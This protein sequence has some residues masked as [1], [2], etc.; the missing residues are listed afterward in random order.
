LVKRFGIGNLLF[1]S[2]IAAVIAAVL[3]RFIALHTPLLFLVLPF[4]LLGITWGLSNAGLITAVNEVISAKK[5][6][7]AL[8]TVATIW[9]VT[10]A[11]ILALSTAIFHAVESHSSFLP[12]FHSAID[13]NIAFAALVLVAAI[14][15][16]T[17]L[18]NKA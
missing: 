12:A 6:G 8:G 1:F 10:G 3:H 16:R 2:V 11:L 7:A 5:I 15:M 14:W 9:N 17:Q 4:F 18:K 13:F